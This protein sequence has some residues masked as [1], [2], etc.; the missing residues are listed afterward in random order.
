MS[1]KHVCTPDVEFKCPFC[2]G[3]V[4]ASEADSSVLHSEPTCEKFKVL[5]PTD[6]LHACNAAMGFLEN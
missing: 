5:D 3:W 6:F 4:A 1:D 2:N